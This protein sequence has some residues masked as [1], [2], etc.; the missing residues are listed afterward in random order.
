MWSQVGE[1]VAESTETKV[2]IV[3]SIEIEKNNRFEW[4]FQYK[5]TPVLYWKF[6]LV[7]KLG[8]R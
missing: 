7:V 5:Q 1:S 8:N 2:T 6:K 4:Q 3:K